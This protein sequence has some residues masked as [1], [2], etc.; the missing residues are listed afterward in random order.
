M[1]ARGGAARST[2]A[3]P[4]EAPAGS[5]QLP[6]WLDVRTTQQEGV[7]LGVLAISHA[8]AW[9]AADS[10]PIVAARAIQE[11]GDGRGGDS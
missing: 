1:L 11:G 10:I 4:G 7:A 9:P 6:H 2:A 5:Q 8:D 3:T